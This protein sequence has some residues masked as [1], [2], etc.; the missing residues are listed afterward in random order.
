M[1][2]TPTVQSTTTAL[3]GR[4]CSRVTRTH[5]T[6]VAP[7]APRSRRR[8]S[9]TAP[10]LSWIPGLELLARQFAGAWPYLEFIA[11]VSGIK[12]PLDRRVVEAYWLGND[13]LERIDMKTF[14]MR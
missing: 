10:Q 5:Q 3:R 9:S 11:G 6:S 2:T 4:R 12:D 13:L 14:G 1:T 8:F 7:V